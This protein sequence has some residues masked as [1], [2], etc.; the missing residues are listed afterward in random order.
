ES[1][2]FDPGLTDLFFELGANVEFWLSMNSMFVGEALSLLIP[3]VK[4]EF[5]YC[6]IRKISQIFSCI[7]DEKSPFTGAHSR[8]ISEKTG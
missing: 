2:K 1:R 6:D 7:I 8:G 3:Q 4:R 5:S